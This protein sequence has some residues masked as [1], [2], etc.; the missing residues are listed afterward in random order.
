MSVIFPEY[1]YVASSWRNTVQPLVC[2]ALTEAG[3]AHYDFKNPEGGTGFSWREVK[4]TPAEPQTWCLNCG[5]EIVL[6]RYH[7][8]GSCEPDYDPAA[9]IKMWRH[10][11][12]GV[13]RGYTS[14]SGQAYRK[15]T[16]GGVR[17]KG[18]DWES[19]DEYL[20]MIAHPRADAGFRSDFDAMQRADT[21]VMVLPCGKSAHLELGW[22]IGAGKR[23][24]I[25]LEDPVEP[26]LMYKMAD[27]LAT[28]LDDLMRW[29]TEVPS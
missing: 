21:F 3:I 23:T 11:T 1:I 15:A 6:A 4:D 25:L 20:R 26:E 28:S 12:G 8:V 18:S 13:K 24:V 14:C 27:Y 22:A 19:V 10:L 17:P 2:A 5:G 9:D 7:D 16:P 29:L